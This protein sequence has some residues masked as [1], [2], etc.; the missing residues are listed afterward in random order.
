MALLALAHR[1]FP[2]QIVAAT[3]DHRLRADAAREA[4]MVAGHCAALGVPHAT[5][6]PATPI[7]GASI[8]ARARDARYALLAEWV[9]AAGAETLATAHHADDQ[10]ETF[11]MRAARGS[12]I[13]GLAGIRP[14]ATIAGI[15]VIRPLLCW[16]RAELRAL[17]A[18]AGA[19]FVDD[20][21]NADPRHDRTHFRA[22]LRDSAWLDPAALARAAAALAEGEEALAAAADLLWA[23]RATTG[24][25]TITLDLS[26]MPRE[27]RRRL[28]RRAIAQVRAAHHITAPEWR[29]SAN[30][31]PLLDALDRGIRA[32]QA[33]VMLSARGDCWTIA[34]AP[35]R[36]T[37]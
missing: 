16:R 22:L 21:A 36:R 20:P 13:A 18:A 3:V 4:A 25:A 19:P 8:Q 10:A 34:A 15:A 2:G 35:P 31:E 28:A 26:A 14:R 37:G 9:R 30:I 1:A 12:G 29:D 33:G 11:L 6:T 24:D 7:S 23:A 17:A 32:T 27:L 5:L